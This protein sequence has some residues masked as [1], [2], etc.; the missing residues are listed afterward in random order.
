LHIADGGQISLSAT[1]DETGVNFTI[2]T[3]GERPREKHEMDK[4]M[5]SFICESLIELHGGHLDMMT[6]TENSAFIMFSIPR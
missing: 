3:S 1:D 6:S 2:Q 4:A 5:Q